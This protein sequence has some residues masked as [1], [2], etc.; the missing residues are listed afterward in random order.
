M[1]NHYLLFFF[2]FLAF[3]LFRAA[4]A[5]YGGSQA[6]GSNHRILNP[7]IESRDGTHNLMVPSQIRFCCAM[8]GALIYL[9]FWLSTCGTWKFPG[10]GSN[11]SHSNDPRH[12]SDN[13]R[14]LTTREQENAYLCS[15]YF[16]S[17]LYDF[18]TSSS[19]VL[20]SVAFVVRLDY[21][22]EIFLVS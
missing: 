17:D 11:S 15:I 20:L 4:L 1:F 18:F 16:W 21:L 2:F 9:L 8:T 13:A 22:F 12:W 3:C 6:R 19:F 14:S 7:L 5:T 10:Q